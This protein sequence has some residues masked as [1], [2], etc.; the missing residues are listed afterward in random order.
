MDSDS[1]YL[2]S[3]LHSFVVF[4]SILALN[5]QVF[6]QA[7]I[8]PVPKQEEVA[9]PHRLT[10][11]I[12]GGINDNFA[13][14]NYSLDNNT[15][16]SG[17]GLGP[18]FFT[19]L[20]IPIAD[21]WM[22]APH[23]SY[24]DFSASFTDGVPT[25]P[26]FAY[27]ART[28]GVDILGKYAFNQLYLLFGPSVSAILKKTFAHGSAGDARASSIDLPGAGNLYPAI[29]G[30]A[31]YDIPINTKHSMWVSPEVFYTVPLANLGP[32]NGNLKAST[33]RL[34]V[35]L[36][37][38]VSNNEVATSKPEPP[39]AV[40]LRAEGIL[41]NGDIT[42]DPIIPEESSRT[43]SSL[44]LLPYVF[45]DNNSDIIPTRYSRSEA[46]GFTEDQLAGK[47][48]LAANHALLDI[49]GSRLKRYPGTRVT[50]TGTNSNARK[51]RKNITLS[52][53]R[54]MSVREYLVKTWNISSDRITIDQRNLPELPTNP[55]TKAGMEENRRVEISSDDP[56][57]T[58][59]VKIEHHSSESAG[60]TRV[61]FET[62]LTNAGNTDFKNWK[63]TLDNNGKYITGESGLGAPSKV[64]TVVIPDPAPYAGKTIHGLLEITDKNGNK[65]I[66]DCMTRIVQKTVEK[67]NL[68]KYGML[69]FDFDSYK[70][71]DRAEK[72]INLI[73][74]SI[75]NDANGVKVTG[76][77]D[78]TGTVDY[79]QALSESRAQ[80]AM[81]VLRSNSRIPANV[82][83]T[84]EGIKDPKFPNG[85]AEGRML[86][87]RVEVDIQKTSRPIN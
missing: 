49:I 39:V 40:S 2:A 80:E 59:P 34:G 41:P 28:L 7:A 36:K 75:T 51:E 20:E 47:D 4:L 31:G 81:K 19:L 16:A 26:N 33:I 56:R 82:V 32:D 8:T 43:R 45:F 85:I 24:N 70:I 77:C 76:Y 46:L 9:W 15:Y 87:R 68:E 69:S 63:L 57:I 58:D 3:L 23:L 54:A 61:R 21:H 18:A 67:E 42:Q 44:P 14:G 6:G 52:R 29:G 11:G 86:N 62:A 73:G 71:N 60:E 13:N 17:S 27:T 35:S 50:L 12:G 66:A 1:Y 65:Y 55:A 5:S 30:G 78:S 22:I 72:M 38:D 79:N 84:G 25:I 83:V 53:N 64:M 74:E 48:A 10:F 37:F